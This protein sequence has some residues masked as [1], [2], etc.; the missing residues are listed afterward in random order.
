MSDTVLEIRDLH[1]RFDLFR[2]SVQ[3][4]R[5]CDLSIAGGEILGLVG[6]SG[7]GKS[8]TATAC[9]GMVPPPGRMSGSIRLCG[10]EIVGAGEANLRHLRGGLAAMIF[11]N[12]S[13]ALNPFFTIG[14]QMRDVIRLHR[15][16]DIAKAGDEAAEA[17]AA[18]RIPDPRAQLRKFPHQL[19][20]GQL[21]RVMIA[22]ALA[23]RPK[24][25]IAD[26]PTTALDVTVQAQILILLRDLA[27]EEGLSVFFIT[28]DLGNVAA[29]CDRVAVM[30]A[31]AL[32]EEG[33]VGDVLG[34]PRHPYTAGLLQSVP[35]LGGGRRRLGAI[36]GRVPDLS[37]PPLGCAFHPRCSRAGE[38][39][40]IEDPAMSFERSQRFACHH[41]LPR[42]A[43][44]R[45]AI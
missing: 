23:C 4:V 20:G 27:R 6:E 28:H 32:V 38:L 30:Y 19:S 12:P 25:L 35:Q 43:E 11:Q 15:R 13:T 16:L 3:A 42:D 31:G 9:L 41:P 40:P 45:E 44:R 1:V 14:R 18:V 21:Q 10:Q 33:S 7:S 37:Q 29:I 22:M 2:R 36:P 26:E 8:V 5:G 24:L 39:C 17:L 34:G